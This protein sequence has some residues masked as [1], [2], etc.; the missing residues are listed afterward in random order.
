MPI[1]WIDGIG[2][3]ATA[4]FLISYRSKDPAVLRRIQAVAASLWMVY[5]LLIHATPVVVANLLVAGIAVYSSLASPRRSAS[6]GTDAV[7]NSP[8]SRS[9]A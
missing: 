5:G 2:W 3:V 7:P 4:I 1:N 8:A 6:H 9:P